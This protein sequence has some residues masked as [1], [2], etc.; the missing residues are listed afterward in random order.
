LPERMRPLD[1]A[2]TRPE[3]EQNQE[4]GN[5]VGWHGGDS[6]RLSLRVRA[7]VKNIARRAY[8][9]RCRVLEEPVLGG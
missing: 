6:S 3:Q 8:G 4:P 1:V 2:E 9:T 5:R 7:G